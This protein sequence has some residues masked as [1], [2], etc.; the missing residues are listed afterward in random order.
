MI[1]NQS[2]GIALHFHKM[3]FDLIKNLLASGFNLQ[4]ALFLKSFGILYLSRVDCQSLL[5]RLPSYNAVS[6]SPGSSCG[7]NVVLERNWNEISFLEVQSLSSA[8]DFIHKNLHPLELLYLV[9]NPSLVNEVFK[10]EVLQIHIYLHFHFYINSL[11][12]WHLYKNYNY[13]NINE[14]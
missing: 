14:Y 8:D 11:F 3:I 10:G 12:L 1:E 9:A 7:S 2:L 5:A 6:D 13:Y 4:L